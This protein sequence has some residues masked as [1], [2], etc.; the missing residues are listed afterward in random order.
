MEKTPYFRMPKCTAAKTILS[1][2]KGRLFLLSMLIL[3]SAECENRFD[4][5]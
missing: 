2:R 4:G 1:D 5:G 3:P